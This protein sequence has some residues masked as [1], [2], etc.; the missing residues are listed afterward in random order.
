MSGL[1]KLS[2][3]SPRIFTNHNYFHGNSSNSTSSLFSPRIFTNHNYFHGNSSNSTSSNKSYIFFNAG[4]IF[5]PQVVALR[6]ARGGRGS[7]ILEFFN[8][9]SN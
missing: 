5:T 4:L 2:L 1:Q 8:K 9:I 3:F 6:N 7:R